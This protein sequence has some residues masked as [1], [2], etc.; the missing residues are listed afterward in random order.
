MT[1]IITAALVAGSLA[2]PPRRFVHE[3][4]VPY[5]IERVSPERIVAICGQKEGQTVLGCYVGW[6][7]STI[8]L[9]TDMTA[10]AAR[11]VL[12]HELGHVNGWEHGR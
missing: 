4:T 7:N 2:M 3:P 5:R 12:R 9:R 1:D 11:L 6:Y 10:D 8:Y